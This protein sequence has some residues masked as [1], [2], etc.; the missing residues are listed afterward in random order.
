AGVVCFL[1]HV[2]GAPRALHLSLHDALPICGWPGTRGPPRRTRSRCPAPARPRPR[3]PWCPARRPRGRVAG[4]G[5]PHHSSA[6][7]FV[8]GTASLP[9]GHEYDPQGHHTGRVPGG[10]V[11]AD[12]PGRVPV[13]SQRSRSFFS[14]RTQ[15]RTI[16]TRVMTRAPRTA[17]HQNSSMTKLRPSGSAIHSVSCSRKALTTKVK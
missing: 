6:L 4:R 12:S 2:H 1:L 15:L 8:T 7:S 9:V 11:C 16:E 5:G 10:S 17:S 3:S 14:G 13:G